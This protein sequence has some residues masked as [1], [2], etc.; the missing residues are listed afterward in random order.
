MNWLSLFAVLLFVTQAPVPVPR[1]ASYRSTSASSTVN[2]QRKSHDAPATPPVAVIDPTAAPS[3][4]PHSD[5]Q[6]QND[7]PHSVVISKFPTVSMNKDWADWG[8]WVFNFMLVV[9]GALQVVML[10]KTLRVIRIQG[11]HMER[12]TV[13]LE[14]S[15]AVAEVGANAAQLSVEQMISR[16]RPRLRVSLEKPILSINKVSGWFEIP[17]KVSIYGTTEAFISESTIYASTGDETGATPSNIPWTPSIFIPQ[18]ILP[19]TEP[20]T[21]NTMLMIPG[22][23]LIEYNEEALNAVREGKKFIYC[24]GWITYRNVFDETWVLKF[25][26]KHNVILG[27]NG[28]ILSSFW[29]NFGKPED[30]G[31]YKAA[32]KKH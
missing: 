8:L 4:Q 21:T 25:S 32:A 18:V 29:V 16:E 23:S 3:S 1:Q 14:K 31:E 19:R 22:S 26:Q 17:L 30:N 5:K 13:I 28:S 11:N 6:G 24:S 7:D 2:S 9:V 12:Q 20:I 15:V 27:Q 10:L